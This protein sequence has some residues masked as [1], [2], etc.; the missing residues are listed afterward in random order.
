MKFDAENKWG[1]FLQ[2]KSYTLALPLGKGSV[3]MQKKTIW[4]VFYRRWEKLVS[5][6]PYPWANRIPKG[7]AKTGC[8]KSDWEE[9]RE[10]RPLHLGKCRGKG[11]GKTHELTKAECD[12]CR[13][14]VNRL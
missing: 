5:L 3:K 8:R 2:S 13:E 1:V 9:R 7:N 11:Q 14:Y 10:L 4:K 12:E 6:W